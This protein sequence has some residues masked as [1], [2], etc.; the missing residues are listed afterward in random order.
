MSSSTNFATKK[1]VEI[2]VQKAVDDL[3]DVIA[4]FAFQ[5]DTR[6]ASLEK[7]NDR[8]EANINRL[9]NTIDAFVK[10]LDDMEIENTSRDS[11]HQRLL[12]WAERV[13]TKT[14][15]PLEY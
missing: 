9:T 10:R 6:F 12:A 3:S 1:D 14:G 11:Q 4:Q 2:I 8:M 5:V 13:S 15:I 7:S